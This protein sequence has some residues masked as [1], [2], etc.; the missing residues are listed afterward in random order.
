MVVLLP[1]VKFGTHEVD[2][3]RPDTGL[4]RK[5]VED[6]AALGPTLEDEGRV[7]FSL[8]S[9]TGPDGGVPVSVLMW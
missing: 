7:R 1:P 5:D 6:D 4:V 8:G 2:S 3:L 9:W